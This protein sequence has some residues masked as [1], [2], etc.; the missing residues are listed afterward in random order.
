MQLSLTDLLASSAES[1]VNSFTETRYTHDEN[2]NVKSGVYDCD[3]SEFVGFVL[4]QVAPEQYALIAATA[5]P[6][7]P[8]AYDFYTFFSNL[9][10]GS[11]AGW[12]PV[13][14]L[15]DASGTL[16][17]ARRGDIVAWR[18]PEIEPK[19]NTGH[20]FFIAEAPSMLDSGRIAVRVYD[21]AAA[22]HFEDTRLDGETG[23][24]SGFINF[25]VDGD[26]R[27]IAFQFG[28]AP[29]TNSFVYWQIAIGRAEPFS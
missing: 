12:S 20:C 21:S 22:A 5:E 3:C 10:P 15:L 18:A 2:I 13:E 9:A 27:P 11:T 28:P 29:D 23:V 4:E 8:L 19:H 7:R 6:P 1:I 14:A 16:S 25:E 17:T 26:G 24:G